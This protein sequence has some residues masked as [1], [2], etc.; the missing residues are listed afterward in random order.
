LSAP[1]LHSQTGFNAEMVV[2]PRTRDTLCFEKAI[3]DDLTLAPKEQM[4]GKSNKSNPV[5]TNSGLQIMISISRS[6]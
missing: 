3:F 4:V 6:T 1:Y 2:H 5:L